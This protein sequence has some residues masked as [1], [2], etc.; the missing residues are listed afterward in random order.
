[1]Y[2]IQPEI[3]GTVQIQLI[4]MSSRELLEEIDQKMIEDLNLSN[5][6]IFIIYTL[7]GSGIVGIIRN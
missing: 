5:Y 1:M 4:D 2:F 3:T 7:Y 6:L